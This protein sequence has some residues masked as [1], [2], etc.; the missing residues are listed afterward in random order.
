LCDADGVRVNRTVHA[1]V[2]EAF[3]G[4]R[5]DG[6]DIDHIN[7]NRKD[8]RQVNLRYVIRAVNTQKS[9]HVKL[10]FEKVTMIKGRLANGATTKVL[11]GEFG[12]TQ[13]TISHIACGRTWKVA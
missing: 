12:V 2:A 1:L 10:D 6:W 13:Q 7:S 11:A 3:I 4:P 9:S 5:P 8:N